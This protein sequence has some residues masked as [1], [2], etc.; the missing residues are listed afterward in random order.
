MALDILPTEDY[1]GRSKERTNMR[2]DALRA[3][4]EHG[5]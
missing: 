5:R 1:G 2:L 3:I 4:E